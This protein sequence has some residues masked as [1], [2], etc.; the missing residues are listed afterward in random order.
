VI[1]ATIRAHALAYYSISGNSLGNF[2]L[3]AKPRGLVS[4]AIFVHLL[5]FPVT[6]P[7]TRKHF[8]AK[9]LGVSA[10]ARAFPKAQ[11]NSPFANEPMAS[12]GMTVTRFEARADAHSM[13][14]PALSL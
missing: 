1:S 4:T 9:L 3:Q 8:F 7:S 11:G 12:G 2:G 5:P 6:Q 13:A 14:R 10:A